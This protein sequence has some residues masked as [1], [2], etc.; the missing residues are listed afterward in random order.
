M[1][2]ILTLEAAFEAGGFSA[3]FAAAAV[4]RAPSFGDMYGVGIVAAVASRASAA[5]VDGNQHIFIFIFV[6]FHGGNRI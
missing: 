3:V 5:V 4:P 2:W 6:L 1:K